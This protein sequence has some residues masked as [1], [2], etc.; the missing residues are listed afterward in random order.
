MERLVSHLVSEVALEGLIG[1][2]YDKLWLIASELSSAS[3]FLG[4]NKQ[5]D[6][7]YLRQSIWQLL[8]H[9]PELKLCI[10]K[11]PPTGEAT[12]ATQNGGKGK[13]KSASKKKNKKGGEGPLEL[14]ELGR[15]YRKKVCVVL[16]A[17][18]RQRLSPEYYAANGDSLCLVATDEYRFICLGIPHTQ[19]EHPFIQTFS[20]KL[21]EEQYCMLEAIGKLD[22]SGHMLCVSYVFHLV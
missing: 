20:S 5:L 15:K 21:S 16:T 17:E 4:E 22:A 6:D 3:V 9:R 10:Y 7:T 18:E 19:I 14:T 2:S 11:D 8:L 12:A 1:C 13:N